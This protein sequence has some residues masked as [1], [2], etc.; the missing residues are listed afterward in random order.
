M[1]K[2]VVE[3]LTDTLLFA[4][5]GVKQVFLQLPPLDS[6]GENI[7]YRFE[8]IHIDA[9]EFPP[10]QRVRTEHAVGSAAGMNDHT[11]SADRTMIAHQRGRA[12]SRL[13]AQLLHDHGCA[14]QQCESPLRITPRGHG[15]APYEFFRPPRARTQQQCLAVRQQFE[16]TAKLDAENLRYERGR[17]IEQLIEVSALKCAPSQVGEGSL[18]TAAQSQRFLRLLAFG[19]VLGDSRDAVHGAVDVANGKGPIMDPSPG[20]VG[21]DDPILFVVVAARLLKESVSKN[22]LAV[23]RMDGLD[24]FPWRRIERLARLAPYLLVS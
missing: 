7:R 20:S 23:L 18:L 21:A 12:K 8:K 9:G 17:V 19:D 24:P 16:R 6:R 13:G 1:A 4:F 10:L 2:P 5:D 22:P 15:F 11:H 14:R 3:I